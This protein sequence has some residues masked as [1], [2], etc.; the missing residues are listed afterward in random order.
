MANEIHKDTDQKTSRHSKYV[1]LLFQFVVG[2]ILYLAQHV[3]D[4][5]NKI[6]T[7]LHFTQLFSMTSF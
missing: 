6:P 4:L 3:C 5:L 2:N 1:K 7:G